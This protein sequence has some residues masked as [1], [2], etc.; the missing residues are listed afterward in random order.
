MKKLL[1]TIVVIFALVFTLS[2]CDTVKSM[3]VKHDVTFHLNGGEASEDYSE[4]IEV[5]DGKTVSLS[6]PTRE[7][8]TFLGWYFGE[9]EITESTPITQDMALKAKWVI[10]TVTVTFVD[11]KGVTICNQTIDWGSSITSVDPAL[12]EREGCDFLGWYLDD[13][14]ITLNTPIT[15]SCVLEGKWDVKSFKVSFV[16]YYGVTISTENVKFGESATAPTVDAIVGNQR[17]DGWSVDYSSIVSDLIVNAVYVDNTYNINYNLGEYGESYTELCFV[18]DVPK[19]PATPEAQGYVFF[20]WYF[21]EELTERY[22]F[23]YVLDV[24]TTLYAKFYDTSL[25]EYTVISNY[26]QLKAIGTV[27]RGKYLLACDINC[28]GDEWV[29]ISDLYGV[30][31]GNGYKIY[32]FTMTSFNDYVGFVGINR[33]GVLKNLSFSDFVMEVHSTHRANS[34]YGV[35]VSINYGLVSNC[36][37]LDGEIKV[38]VNTTISEL[39]VGGV[40]GRNGDLNGSGKIENC[41]NNALIN[42]DFTQ[43]SGETYYYV[44]GIVGI[45]RPLGE[46][47][48]CVNYGEIR[49]LLTAGG[50]RVSSS[51]KLYSVGGI[52]GRNEGKLQESYSIADVYAKVKELNSGYGSY[53]NIG[54]A[55]GYNMG[56]IYNCYSTGNVYREGPASDFFMGGFVGKNE[57]YTGYSATITKCFSTGNVQFGDGETTNAYYGEFTGW[58][59]GAIKD[60]FYI[61][62]ATIARVTIVD[63]VE[64]IEYL[65]VSY[66]ENT[67]YPVG[68]KKSEADLLD[69]EFLENVLYFDRMVWFIVEGK[70]PT[71]R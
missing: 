17:F 55:V 21:D 16:D 1:S 65:D 66:A 19:I 61:D 41:T 37:I 22:F 42:V 47:Y 43:D 53:V 69:A 63:D 71:L 18:G 58:N 25:G 44:G 40:V 26:E 5:G 13:T 24:D 29:R 62:T 52:T 60:C 49:S 9:T 45:N 64:T 12:T 54:G 39:N 8:Y 23:D 27:P 33:G 56:K 50:V 32:N 4:S 15:Q 7:G 2:A 3:V 36:H 20:G 38:I 70:L 35:A 6:T 14:K 34:L 68:E 30:I 48:G 28:H 51:P 59:N 11:D 31:D 67:V 46:I 10:N 57:L